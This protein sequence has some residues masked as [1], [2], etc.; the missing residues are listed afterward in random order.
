MES[1]QSS[2]SNITAYYEIELKLKTVNPMFFLKAYLKIDFPKQN[3]RT[4]LGRLWKINKGEA[5]A[6]LLMQGPVTLTVIMNRKKIGNIYKKYSEIFADS[7]IKLE[8]TLAKAQNAN[9]KMFLETFMDLNKIGIEMN[10]LLLKEIEKNLE[11]RNMKEKLIVEPT[12]E[13][14]LNLWKSTKDILDLERRIS[15]IMTKKAEIQD[16][17]IKIEAKMNK[18]DKKDL[19]DFVKALLI[20]LATSYEVQRVLLIGSPIELLFKSSKIAVRIKKSFYFS[21]MLRESAKA[22]DEWSNFLTN[23]F[24]AYKEATLC[25]VKS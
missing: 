12:T 24:L 25:P 9:R 3:S 23:W 22:K 21:D 17:V 4:L 14:I 1:Y 13:N 8:K 11:I 5:L 20:D 16:R 15:H 2:L 10:S 19:E 18:L 6:G 7:N